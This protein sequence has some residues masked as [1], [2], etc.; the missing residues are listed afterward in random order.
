MNE[1]YR[2]TEWKVGLFI[3]IGICL[4]AF[5]S[6]KF[7]KLGQGLEKFYAINVEFP[8]ASGLLKGGDVLM[9]GARVGFA[10]DAPMLVEGRYAVTVPLRVRAG[11][12]IPK[13]A[14]F[15][16]G[17]SGMMGDA[18]VSIELP[19]N[20]DMNTLLQD[21]DNV[22]GTRIKGIT[23]L[24][25]E[26][27]GVIEEMKK[28]L[29]E[30]EQ[31]IKDVRE[32]LLGQKNLKN[33]EESISNFRETTVNLKETS[34]GLDDVVAKAKE[35]ATTL[36]EAMDTAKSAMGKVDGVVVK[37]DVAA[38]DLKSAIGDFR[39]VA[40]TATKALDSA[41]AL[42][43]KASNGQGALGLLI[44]DQEMASNLKT[45][46]RNLREHGVL[47]YKDKEKK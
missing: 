27:G 11:V 28:R 47:W 9:F 20:P 36:K 41:K 23:E 22:V 35:A 30:L 42:I 24:T 14:I 26:S 17:S 37:V 5:L 25:A 12:K 13:G 2:G 7:G 46:I 15:I 8:N 21:G 31:P 19:P 3:L 45:L 32:G 39:K 18:Y 40:D 4:I 34:R 1:Q 33:L 6:V 16:I 44:S 10:K 38:T 29:Q 43:N